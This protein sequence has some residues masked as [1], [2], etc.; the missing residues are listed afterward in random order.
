MNWFMFKNSVIIVFTILFLLYAGYWL[1]K[2]I[3]ACSILWWRTG[4]F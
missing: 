4:I 2:F 1:G 3:I